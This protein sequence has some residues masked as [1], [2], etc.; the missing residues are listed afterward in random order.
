MFSLPASA[1]PRSISPP[2]SLF[3]Y[4][5]IRVTRRPRKSTGN[6]KLTLHANAL[7]T[8]KR[9]DKTSM[10]A[11]MTRWRSRNS[12]Q[13]SDRRTHTPPTGRKHDNN[14]T[15]FGHLRFDKPLG[16]QKYRGVT[17]PSPTC[18][19]RRGLYS[20]SA[21]GK[22]ARFVRPSENNKRL[23][24]PQHVRHFGF[25]LMAGECMMGRAAARCC[26]NVHRGGFLFFLNI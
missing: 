23:I 19:S 17:G 1:E 13:L 10:L 4:P 11:G 16:Q 22:P 9:G 15:S 3:D 26:C 21:S 24:F 6:L 8:K 12:G 18:L 2:F 5:K 20:E 7:L 25:P 14:N